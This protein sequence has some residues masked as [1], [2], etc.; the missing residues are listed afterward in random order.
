MMMVVEGDEHRIASSPLQ[1]DTDS[2]F[3]CASC[4][5][6]LT[7]WLGWLETCPR[8]CVFAGRL[9]WLRF[10]VPFLLAGRAVLLLPLK[11]QEENPHLIFPAQL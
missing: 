8:V 11:F 5:F 4:S 1:R 6:W 3:G 2:G 10:R 9:C 7:G